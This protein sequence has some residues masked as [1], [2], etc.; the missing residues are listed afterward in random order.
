LSTGAIIYVGVGIY[1]VVMLIIGIWASSRTGSTDNFIV[2][3]RS[4]PIWLASATLAATW[5]G[6]GT[7]I[8]AAGASYEGGLLGVI[9]DPFG[10]ALVFFLVG[11]FFVRI[12]RRLRLLTVIDFFE[13]RYG[14]TAA[15]IA[16]SGI[17][18]SNIGWTAGLLVAFGI[19]FQSL[20]GI[21]M[22]VGILA[23]AFVVFVRRRMGRNFATIAGGDVSHHPGRKLLGS[24]VQ[25][26]PRVAD[27]WIGG[28]DGADTAAARFCGEERAGRAKLVLP[29]R[30]LV[31][32]TWHG[33]G[34]ARHHRQRHAARARRAGIRHSGTR[35]GTPASGR[36]CHIRR[37]IDCRGDEQRG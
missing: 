1:L 31:P 27:F 26:Y 19:V 23:G 17:I 21:P 9:A 10:A 29:R 30:F 3:G 7:I 36:C 32:G 15:T 22:E 8:G 12:F 6:G 28:H 35:A 5:F 34:D 20:T 13:N 2:A 4:M 11:F 16:A 14:K 24:M 37:R 33:P 18:I 25:L